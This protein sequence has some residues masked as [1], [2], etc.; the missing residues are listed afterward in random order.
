MIQL[1]ISHQSDTHTRTHAHADSVSERGGS[2]FRR[3]RPRAGC[4]AAVANATY[5]ALRLCGHSFEHRSDARLPL[6]HRDA[7]Q[8]ASVRRAR[9]PS[10]D[11]AASRGDGVT[12][13]A[14]FAVV[15][16]S[17]SA[18]RGSYHAGSRS[19]AL[20]APTARCRAP[21]YLKYSCARGVEQF[22]IL[23]VLGFSRRRDM[24]YAQSIFAYAGTRCREEGVRA[25][26][27]PS[28]PPR[29]FYEQ[30]VMLTRARARCRCRSAGGE[31]AEQEGQEELLVAP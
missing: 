8:E 3:W 16:R 25:P 20:T 4:A 30:P 22:A 24:Y 5:C 7:R 2:K 10:L 29:A 13:A 15:S 28:Q 26:R 11:V 6:Q 1:F 17:A 12:V 21:R 31:G 23:Y 18:R 14:R 9:R 19:R 27:H